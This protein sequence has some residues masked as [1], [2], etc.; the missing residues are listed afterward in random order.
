M[1]KG[2]FKTLGNKNTHLVVL[3][4]IVIAPILFC[5][6]IYCF[7]EIVHIRHNSRVSDVE[8]N[9]SCSVGSRKHLLR[10]MLLL[11]YTFM[12]PKSSPEPARRNKETKKNFLYLPGRLLYIYVQE[13]KITVHI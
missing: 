1:T 13:N 4:S 10:I 6:G 8:V 9:G 7:F 3:V 5:F 12:H 11:I 2:N